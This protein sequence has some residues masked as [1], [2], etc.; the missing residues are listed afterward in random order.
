MNSD[1]LVVVRGGGDLATGV[2]YALWCAGYRVMALEVERPS[3]IRRKVCLCEAVYDGECS[4]EGIHCVLCKNF[5]QAQQAIGRRQVPMLVDP[6]A[7]IVAQAK[8]F[9]LVDAILAKRNLGTN[10]TMAPITVALGP[11]FEAGKDVDLVV[12]TMRGHHLGR[13]IERG[14]AIA[15]TGVPAEIAGYGEKRVIHAPADGKITNLKKISDLVCEGERIAEIRT[16][17]RRTVPVLAPMSG[18]LRGMIRNGFKV[19][20][21]LKIADIDPREQERDNCFTISDKARALGGAVVVAIGKLSQ[22]TKKDPFIYLDN[23]AT[24]LQ[25]PDCVK[26]AILEAMDCLGNEGRGANH[27]TLN[28]SRSIFA[29]REQLSRLFDA[30]GPERVCFTQ[31]ATVALNTA[32]NGAIYAGDEVVT[33]VMEHNSVLRPLY[34]LERERSVRLTVV[35]CNENG[36]L[37]LAAMHQAIRK[38]PK[39][40]VCTH[41][42]NLTGNVNNLQEI[43]KM[44]KANGVLLIVD[45]S[46]TAGVLPISMKK[47][48]IDILC[49]AGHK[50]LFGPQGTGG[51]I[52]QKS[53]DLS[54]LTV[55]GS[56]ILTF[57]QQHPAVMPAALEAGTLN[58]P[59]VCGLASGVDFVCSVGMHTI[60]SLIQERVRLFLTGVRSIPGLKLYGDFNA[61]HIGVI[62]LNLGD[63]DSSIVGD[64]LNEKYHIAVRTGGH[65]AP[66]MHRWFH[67]Q[68]QGMV[69]F[70]FSYFTT[71]EQVQAAVNALKEI[72]QELSDGRE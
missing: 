59:G 5:E 58:A 51:L 63:A 67:T 12:E 52:V 13:L 10:R 71:G 46:Q 18:L 27:F 49:F 8:P 54:P 36:V 22:R 9:A 69:R 29:A 44:C 6:E 72:A 48:G 23:A 43:G 24:T 11:G 39:A 30:D 40:V 26:Q 17:N 66:L 1:K 7:G 62:S 42:S 25:K 19:R 41:A 32:I 3:A 31:N 68:D 65:C 16:L 21:G 35:G 28:A 45:A 70:S 47:I 4:V 55:G 57:D 64:R 56:G 50:A 14:C 20:K 37:D 38:K 33:T 15:N 34:R 2:I 61:N 53:V 60:H